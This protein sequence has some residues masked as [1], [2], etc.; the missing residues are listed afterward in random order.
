MRLTDSADTVVFA[1]G[2]PVLTPTVQFDITPTL[3]H[4]ATWTAAADRLLIALDA[5]QPTTFY[6]L[7]FTPGARAESG[8]NLSCRIQS[9]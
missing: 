4:T 5:A 7:Q 1:F 9:A 6:Q 3:N 2:Q 8:V